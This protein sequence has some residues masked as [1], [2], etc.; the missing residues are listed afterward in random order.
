MKEQSL[1]CEA[2]IVSTSPPWFLV[3][4][5]FCDSLELFSSDS[6]VFLSDVAGVRGGLSNFSR[7]SIEAC[8]LVPV[9]K[10]HS[11]TAEKRPPLDSAGA[12]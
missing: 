5:K 6:Q 10:E 11:Q 1:A 7:G 2:R 3:T 9:V 12:N 4:H 8:D